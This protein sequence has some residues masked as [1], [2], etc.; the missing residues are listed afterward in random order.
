MSWLLRNSN[1]YTR[2][3]KVIIVFLLFHATFKKYSHFCWNDSRPGNKFNI[4]DRHSPCIS[5]KSNKIRHLIVS[6]VLKTPYFFRIQYGCWDFSRSFSLG[7]NLMFR[8][9]FWSGLY[10]PHHEKTCFMSYTN[11]KGADQPANRRSLIS[12]FVVRCLSR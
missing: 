6:N 5:S 10:E 4:N 2:G 1:S 12:T 3:K 8:T 7:N 9:K 11:N